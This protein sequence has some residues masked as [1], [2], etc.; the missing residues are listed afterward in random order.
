MTEMETKFATIGPEQITVGDYVPTDAFFGAAYIDRD[1]M[2]DRPMRHRVLHGGFADS[3]TRFTF[4]F[5]PG[6]GY[7]GRMFQPMEGGHA[8]HENIFG[9]GPVAEISGGLAMA[10]RLGGYMVESNCGHIGDDIDERAGP[11]PTLYGYRAAVESAR[12][13]RHVARQIYGAEP[14]NGY[15]Y[16]GSGGGRRSPACLEYGADVY[17]GALPY[18]SGGNIEPHGTQS[19]VRSEQPVHFGLMFNVKRLL[20]D[21]LAGVVDAMQPGGSG[22]PFEGLSF[23]Q[24]EELANLY[25]LGF[26][27]GSE[28]MIGQP[29]GQIWLWTSIAD[30]LLEEDADYF[31]NFWEQPGYIG[32]DEPQWVEPDRINTEV[33]VKRVLSARD[34]K[35]DPA[36]ATDPEI[37]AAAYPAIFIATLNHTL[38]LPTAVEVELPE[39]G[40]RQGAGV[41][42]Q[43]GDAKGR[44]LYAMAEAKGIFLCDGRGDANLKRL[45]GVRPG[46][47]VRIDNRPFL[48]YCYYYRHHLSDDPICDFLRVDGQPLLPQHDVPL[49]SP[50]MGVPYC[51]EYQGKLMWIHATHDTSLWPPQG[52]SYYRAVELAQ[53]AAGLKN[54]FCIRWTENSEHTP[55]M[56]VPPQPNRSGANW[57]INFQGIVEQS[58]VDLI[59]WVE[60]GKKPVGT[61]FSFADGKVILPQSAGERGGI[62]PVVRLRTGDG[63]QVCEVKVGEPV[64]LVAQAEAPSG[65]K[66][67]ALEWDFDGKGAYSVSHPVAGDQAA[68]EAGERHAFDRAGT[69]FP[70]VRV[71]AHRDGEVGAQQRRLENVASVRVVVR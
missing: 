38:D 27:R 42:I 49:A 56:M 19:R 47:R 14:A 39:G 25:R 71:T 20:G 22:N 37:Q 63:G 41:Y 57:L 53:G 45:E 61:A 69:Y 15:V 36:F 24:R 4:Y 3:D 59:D 23:H 64:A 70:S 43:S 46:D 11:D 7:A 66:I 48:A 31:R 55:P 34:L 62:Q 33:V 35:E 6:E 5:Q 65:G 26:P 40:F 58:L 10:F 51:G 68:L 60:H 29:F 13:S 17:T 2:R 30:M 21:R 67:I 18:H 1:E 52:L 28:L 9:E 44:R 16:G 50:L 8:G 32:H 54:N 12:F